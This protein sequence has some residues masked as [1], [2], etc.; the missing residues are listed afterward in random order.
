MAAAGTWWH[1]EWQTGRYRDAEMLDHVFTDAIG[2]LRDA[3]ESAFLER[4]AFE[5]RFQSDLL[6]GDIT[7]ET[8][9]SLPGED[10]PPRVRADLTIQWPTWS[11]TSYRNWYLGDGLTDPPRIDIE[12][13][14][15]VQ[16]LKAEPDPAPLIAALA[17]EGPAVGADRLT[18]SGPSVETLYSTD[19]K[20]SEYSIEVTYDGTYELD[21]ASL[22]DGSELDEH[23]STIGVWVAS[24]LVRLGDTMLG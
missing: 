14:F 1:G 17:D 23:F 13:T 10:L 8:I 6:L 21:E 3:L 5:E 7:W 15:R 2:A 24:S 11:Q 9:Y 18:R 4:Q 20:A 12:V 19:L 16:R 22:A